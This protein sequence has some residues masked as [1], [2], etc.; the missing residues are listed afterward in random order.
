MI[1]TPERRYWRHWR[2]SGVIIVWRSSGVFIDFERI[3]HFFSTASV[4]GFEQVN[5]LFSD[6]QLELGQPKRFFMTSGNIKKPDFIFSRGI[7]RN[8]WHEMGPSQ[9]NRTFLLPLFS[10]SEV[11][12]NLFP[13][14]KKNRVHNSNFNNMKLIKQEQSSLNNPF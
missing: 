1:K 6:S 14:Y 10:P 13:F 11:F 12:N 2:R 8:Q 7:E 4:V 3:S 5:V 9:I